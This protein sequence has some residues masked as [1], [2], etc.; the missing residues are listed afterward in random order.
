MNAIKR[1]YEFAF[2]EQDF[3]RIRKMIREHAGISLSESK[4]E[5]VYSRMAPLLRKNGSKT[6]A[7]Y[8]DRLQR[9]NEAEWTDFT[10]SLTTN[11]TSFFREEH[12]FP[13]LA[14]HLRK[15]GK[16]RPIVLW[17]SACSTGE[18]AYSMAMTVVDAM[19]GFDH[20]V[21]IIAS[22]LDT[23]V[24]QI[25]QAGR[26]NLDSVARMTPQQIDK[27]FVRGKGADADFVTVRRELQEMIVFRK[28]NLLDGNWPIRAPVDVIFCRNVM[29]YFDK[30]TQLAIL[31]KFAPLLS[32]DG[33][34][35]AGHSESFYHANALF[36]LRGHTVYELAGKERQADVTP[37]EKKDMPPAAKL[38]W[39]G[40]AAPV[41]SKSGAVSASLSRRVI[42]VGS[43]TGGTDALRVF[44]KDVPANT[45]AILIAQHMPELF[46]K[47][48][49]AR[50]DGLCPMR[51]KEAEHNEM[52]RDGT[53][54]LAPG[55][56][57]M[58]LE[59]AEGGYRIVLNQQPPVNRHRPS[60]EVLFQSAAAVLGG[61][62]VG[63]MLTGMG[64]DGAAAMLEMHK[65]GAYNLAQDEASCVVFGM[66]REAI[67]LG[68]V[69]EV[70]PL[71]QMAARALSRIAGAK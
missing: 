48:F 1:S 9:S 14:Q 5:L 19:G 57:H 29:I 3:Q 64:K 69:D 13:I 38:E 28:I 62:A 35:F 10:N 65:A 68:A 6:F 2:T 53:V 56:S 32:S 40:T 51:V 11:L 18:E 58:L 42:V 39:K 41:P 45:P 34:L 20:R 44:L 16:D 25:A 66:P 8:L 54:Y 61:N 26:Y 43:S 4:Q 7:E 17:C 71:D 50:L 55:H 63:V 37:A 30:D 23:K 15:L 60:V 59:R 22:D 70:V 52:I 24:L 49:A 47:S 31:K 46:T 36:R 67:A 21:S 12:H 33:L 27:F